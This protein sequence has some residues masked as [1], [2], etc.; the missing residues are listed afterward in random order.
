MSTAVV[1]D[2]NVSLPADVTHRLPLFFA[3]LEVRIGGRVYAD[4]VDIAPADFYELLRSSD[5]FPTTSAPSPGAF[6][7]AFRRAGEAAD[8]IVCITLSADLSAAHSA[9]EEA[10]RLAGTQLPHLRVS[11]VDSRSAGAAQG[12]IALDA[13]RSAAS[14]A[15]TDDVLVRIQRRIGDT[16][17]IGY[18]DTLYYLWRG[19]RV[20]RLFMWMGSILKLKPILQ[21]SAGRIGMVERPRTEAKALARLTAIAAERTEGRPTRA[22]VMHAAEPGKA[23]MLAERLRS[24]LRIEELF[25]TEFTPAIGAHTGPGLVGCAFHPVD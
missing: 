12:L 7:D 6:L 9:A 15:S 17:F 18:L 1:S 16:H 10:V 5:E 25:I 2:S 4:G 3:P 23:E 14:G 22:A 19:G 24:H 8:D 13:A 21:L 11:L 20:P